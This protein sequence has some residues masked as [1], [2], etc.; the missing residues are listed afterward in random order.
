MF[1]PLFIGL[2]NFINKHI[3]NKLKPYPMADESLV[4][5]EQNVAVAVISPQMIEDTESPK[6][7]TV[8]ITFLGITMLISSFVIGYFLY[9]LW[10]VMKDGGEQIAFS[11]KP[12]GWEKVSYIFGKAYTFSSEQRLLILVLLAGAMGSFIH[13]ATSFSNYVGEGKIDRKWIW[14]YILRPII[15]MAV[16]LTFYMIFRAGL[17][18]GMQIELLNIYGVLTLAAL[19]GLFTDRATLKLEEIFQSLFKPKDDRADKLKS[20]AKDDFENPQA[21]S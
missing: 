2:A 14:W 15:G 8:S 7:S 20:T 16:A 4:P 17:F 5:T 6:I 12:P 1:Y 18:A 11:S 19:S 13:A 21:Q 3:T 9:A 10:P